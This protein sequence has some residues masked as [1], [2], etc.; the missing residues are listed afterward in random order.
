[1]HSR[2]RSAIALGGGEIGKS[3]R[4]FGNSKSAESFKGLQRGPSKGTQS[5][6]IKIPTKHIFAPNVSVESASM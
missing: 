6:P 2:H 5:I 3:S 4:N 1:M